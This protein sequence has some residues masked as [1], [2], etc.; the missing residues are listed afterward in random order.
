MRHKIYRRSGEVMRKKTKVNTAKKPIQF[1][2]FVLILL[3]GVVSVQM[4]SLYAR[5]LKLEEETI[6]LERHIKHGIE[7][8]VSLLGQKQFMY[9]EEYVEKLAREKLGLI[10]PNEIIYI[11]EH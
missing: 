3:I 6:V 9:S 7:E 8:Q 11:N 10:K 4:S 5:N 2:V 1:M